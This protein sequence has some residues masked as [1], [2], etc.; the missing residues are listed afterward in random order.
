[1]TAFYG[2]HSMQVFSNFLVIISKR[3]PDSQ[4]ALGAANS[5]DWGM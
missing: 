4:S 1:M 3:Y 2:Q 5:L